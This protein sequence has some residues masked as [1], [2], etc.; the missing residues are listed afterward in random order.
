MTDDARARAAAVLAE[1]YSLKPGDVSE[2]WD[3][4][5]ITLIADAVAQAVKERDHWESEVRLFART[6][7]RQAE[8]IARLTQDK[9]L[10]MRKW[11]EEKARADSHFKEIARLQE[12]LDAHAKIVAEAVANAVA[13]E[14]MELDAYLMKMER[15][16]TDE[17]AQAVKERKVQHVCTHCGYVTITQNIT[18][19][20]NKLTKKIAQLYYGQH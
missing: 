17:K 9:E 11:S 5:E 12:R 1:V 8:E 18:T 20:F 10:W 14:R 6:I 15:I 7:D 4:R 19:T 13:E 2:K 3:A 16:W